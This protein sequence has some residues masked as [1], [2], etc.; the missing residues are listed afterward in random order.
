[1]ANSS[2]LELRES[3]TNRPCDPSAIVPEWVGLILEAPPTGLG[4]ADPFELL[5]SLSLSFV[6][7]ASFSFFVAPPE[8]FPF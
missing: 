8:W 5:L 6:G 2:T 7:E 1:M 3:P 4:P